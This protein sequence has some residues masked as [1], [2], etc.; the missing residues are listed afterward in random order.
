MKMRCI[1][2][3]DLHGKKHRYNALFSIIKKEKPDGVFMGGDLLPGGFGITLDVTQFIQNELLSKISKI[4]KEG[5]TTE[6]FV[7]LGNDDPK[8]YEDQLITAEQEGLL[9][10]VNNKTTQF[11]ELFVSGY[12]YIPPSPFSLKDW[13]RYDVSRYVDPGSLSPEEGLRTVE[14]D[15]QHERYRTIAEDLKQLQ[16][17]SPPQKTIYLFHTP[18]HNTNLDRADLDG[19]KIDHVALDVHIGSIAVKR[20]ITEKKP[21]LTLHGHVHE[22]PRLTGIWHE[23]IGPTHLY[24]AAH[25]GSELAVITFDTDKL[26]NATRIL[27]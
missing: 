23:T 18:P 26:E 10:Y 12:S 20:F 13:E 1:F 21:L 24:S 25:D 15:I 9:H 3:S 22:S 11:K 7:I 4:K 19:K 8:I 6:F 27:L 17:Q 5:I 2:V 16:T 14:I